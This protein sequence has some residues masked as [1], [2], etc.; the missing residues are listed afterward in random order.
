MLWRKWTRGFRISLHWKFCYV[1]VTA[2]PL[3]WSGD[4]V[5]P[6][7]SVLP[8]NPCIWQIGQKTT[9]YVSDIWTPL[10]ELC[11]ELWRGKLPQE[12]ADH[13]SSD[14]ARIYT[15]RDCFCDMKSKKNL[16]GF[17]EWETWSKVLRGREMDLVTDADIP[18]GFWYIIRC[19]HWLEYTF[20]TL[21][22][23]A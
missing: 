5:H 9:C 14:F 15:R 21:H 19:C 17:Y 18:T 8:A 1:G 22:Y 10:D 3:K 4:E 6:F 23:S 13:S 12:W 7:W 11:N 2:L 16:Y 20:L